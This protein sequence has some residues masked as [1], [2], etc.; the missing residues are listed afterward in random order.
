MSTPELAGESGGLS[1]PAIK[2]IIRYL[3]KCHREEAGVTD[4]WDIEAS[5]V[6]G[7]LFA[8]GDEM[9]FSGMADSTV[10][11][12]SAARRM[13][14]EALLSK[15]D[16][17][18]F[19]THFFLL[20]RTNYNPTKGVQTICA[21]LFL[22]SVTLHASDDAAVAT[23]TNNEWRCHRPLLQHYSRPEEAIP[24]PDAVEDLLS[25]NG[26]NLSSQLQLVGL[27][28]NHIPDLDT[29]L[30]E[31]L[32]GLL[33]LDQLRKI[34]KSMGDQRSA[35]VLV[36]SALVM[37]SRK[38]LSS[39]GLLH[40]VE[41][42]HTAP[43]ISKPLKAILSRVRETNPEIDP[44]EKLRLPANL[45][46][47][48]KQILLSARRKNLTV[49][50]GPPGTGKSFTSACLAV[51]HLARGQKVLVVSK[52]SRAVSVAGEKISEVMG[53]SL[54]IMKSEGH[55]SLDRQKRFLSEILKGMHLG[56]EIGE[57][58]SAQ[59]AEVLGKAES[60][61]RSARRNY[62]AAL[63]DEIT[64]NDLSPDGLSLWKKTQRWLARRRRSKSPLHDCQ[65]RYFELVDRRSAVVTAWLRQLRIE[66]LRRYLETKRNTVLALSK[67]L[68][69]RIGHRQEDLWKTI[70]P[71]ELLDLFPLWVCELRDLHRML[72]MNQE[73]FDL[74]IFDEASQC[75]LASAMPAMQ[76]AKRMVVA[77]D[78]CQLRHLS[79]LPLK[80]MEFH[81]RSEALDETTAEDLNYR[82]RSLLDVAMDRVDSQS[83]VGFLSEHFRSQPSLIRF[84]NKRFYS[85]QL[86]VMRETPWSDNSCLMKQHVSGTRDPSGANPEEGHALL[87]WLADHLSNFDE[88][89]SIG[90]ISPFRAQVD[91]LI[92]HAAKI[93]GAGA[94]EQL[95]SYNQ[96]LI[97][98]V[99][100]FQGE[101][102][103]LMLISTVVTDSCPAASLR[104]LETPNI[105]NVMVT[106][107]KNTQVIFHSVDEHSDTK[108]MLNS[109]LREVDL[110]ENGNSST[111]KVNPTLRAQL[112]K[113][114]ATA[115]ENR[116]CEVNC[117]TTLAGSPC[118]MAIRS[119]DG[120][121]YATDILGAGFEYDRVGAKEI[122]AQ[123]R[124]AGMV[125]RVIST[126]IWQDNPDLCMDRFLIPANH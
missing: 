5:R 72:P 57:S 34:R 116:G 79:F 70:D 40:E 123:W 4:V 29:S 119:P 99:H 43:R 44:D 101:E 117:H 2:H 88:G 118:D 103:D 23:I 56:S 74:V 1:D 86:L 106:R 95:V 22:R 114:I 120:T 11:R 109:Y 69:T 15:R 68:R 71:A 107:A 33:P 81:A 26:F 37:L 17:E 87:Q 82:N 105:F 93:F 9:L 58:T 83:S 35:P 45:T 24:L 91:W 98:T 28:K 112:L 80:R 55:D 126:R 25:K 84:S 32:S 60:Q 41:S 73:M 31:N 85:D 36:P 78:P 50:V 124:R 100:G 52:S 13:E 75:D 10:V 61:L 94:M 8:D 67:L 65:L 92:D 102:R 19:Y 113:E 54:V 111:D 59:L 51:D 6:E 76:R 38:P 110:P 47:A 63:R 97:T 66:K 122:Y 49:I 48:Q 108:S 30:L 125:P 104:F 77:G 16:K 121:I 21:P 12:G 7:L 18:L 46:K 27:L 89:I 90:I 53:S 96:L 62:N 14:N 42:I 115:F 64:L 3:T 20:D 39:A